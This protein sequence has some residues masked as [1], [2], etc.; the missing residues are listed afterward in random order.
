MGRNL[1]QSKPEIGRAYNTVVNLEAMQPV[2]GAA[3]AVLAPRWEAYRLVSTGDPSFICQPHDCDAHCCRKF[4]VSLGQA[5]VD[6]LQRSSELLPAEFLEVE[7]GRPVTLPLANPYVLARRG[8]GCALLGDDLSCTQYHARPGACR[9]YPHFV[10]AFDT[11]AGRPA[12][13]PDMG[14]SELVANLL[15]GRAETVVPLL[16]RHVE[17]PGFTGPPLSDEAWAE[18]FR[19]TA[20]MQSAVDGSAG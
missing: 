4:T 3:W 19:A 13:V 14:L 7:N 8:N 16:L 1:A 18:L 5:E 20:A 2:I 11:A 10:V 17:C 9:L 12:R 6:R 15:S